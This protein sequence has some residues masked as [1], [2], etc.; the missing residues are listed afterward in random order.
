MKC[1]SKNSFWQKKPTFTLGEELLG[2]L[3]FK[4]NEFYQQTEEIDAENSQDML[5]VAK[6]G[7]LYFRCQVRQKTEDDK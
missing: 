7:E 2:H 4:T 3:T 1:N 5:K 6:A